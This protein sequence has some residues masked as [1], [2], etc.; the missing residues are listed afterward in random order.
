M[1]LCNLQNVLNLWKWNSI[2]IKQ[3]L[4][5]PSPATTILYSIP[6]NLSS[7]D[8]SEKCLSFCEWLIKHCINTV[9]VILWMAYFSQ[10]N[11]LRV[12]PCCIY[13]KVFLFFFFLIS[14]CMYIPHFVYPWINGW[15]FEFLPYLTVVT[16]TALNISIQISLQGPAFTSFGYTA[17]KGIWPRWFLCSGKLEKDWIQMWEILAVDNNWTMSIL[18][19]LSCLLVRHDFKRWWEW[20]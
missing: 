18:I 19:L 2:P 17:Q 20:K 10:H 12:H 14:Y 8:T 9:F 4:H 6:M 16:N 11:A 1:V 3:F 15:K 13:V 7:L 5:L